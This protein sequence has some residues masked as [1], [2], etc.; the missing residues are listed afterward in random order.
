M[1][2]AHVVIVTGLSGS[3]K[4]TAIKALEDVGFF[5]ID[6]LPIVLMDKFLTLAE[7]HEEIRR[8]ALGIDARERRFLDRF[9]ETVSRVREDGH[10][11]DVL[12]LDCDDDVLMRRYSETRRRHPLEPETGSLAAGI[13]AERKLLASVR[14]AATWPLDTS[15]LNLHQLKAMVQ[16]AYGTAGSRRM[17]VS[18]VS[19]GFKHGAP[20]EADWQIDC[21]LLPNPYFVEGLRPKTGLDPEVRAFL[22][23]REEWGPFLDHLER[24]LRFALPLHEAEGKPMLTVALG[25]TGGQHRSVAVCEALAARLREDGVLVRVSHR[26]LAVQAEEPGKES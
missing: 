26:E 19:F 23:A 24:L 17:G 4:S 14:D 5:C 18:L 10:R 1:K 13:E 12:F 3:G 8:V 20:R 25:C 2:T 21:R 15:R 7:H 22:E 11:V 6:N 16:Q 9:Q